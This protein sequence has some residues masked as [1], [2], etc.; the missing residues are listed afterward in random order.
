MEPSCLLT[1]GKNETGYEVMELLKEVLSA[2]D[3]SVEKDPTEA[4]DDEFRLY[5]FYHYADEPYDNVLEE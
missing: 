1:V 2:L 4:E 5:R 3:I